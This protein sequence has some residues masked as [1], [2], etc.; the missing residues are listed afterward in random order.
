MEKS[1]G[2]SRGELA[3]VL[4]NSCSSPGLPGLLIFL[5]KQKYLFCVTLAH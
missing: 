4:E 1:V 2:A 5:E 3:M